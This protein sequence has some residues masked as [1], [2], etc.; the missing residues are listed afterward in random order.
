M[1]IQFNPFTGNL[2]LIG[3]GS[4]ATV[5]TG[6]TDVP[7]SYTGQAG[8]GVRV[9][10]TEDGLEFYSASGAVN[11]A[12]N[13]TPSGTINGSNPTFTLAHTPISGSLMLLLNGAFQTL[14]TDY[15]L[16]TATITFG[17]APVGGSVLRAF[18]QY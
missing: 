16:A 5:F 6:L 1:Q 12:Y 10:A 9:K 4:G 2:D 13:E 8:K 14:T 7:Q 15:T 17:T 11:S 18:Y 3:T